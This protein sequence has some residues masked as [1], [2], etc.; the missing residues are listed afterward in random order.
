MLP[1]HAAARAPKVLCLTT[2]CPKQRTHT[3]PPR[4]C[5]AARARLH[6]GAQISDGPCNTAGIPIKRLRGIKRLEF[7]T[8]TNGD[9]RNRKVYSPNIAGPS[10][11]SVILTDCIEH[12]GEQDP[13]GKCAG[14]RMT[15]ACYDLSFP[16]P[17]QTRSRRSSRG[18][19][20]EPCV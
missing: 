6:A 1:P 10:A 8:D 14:G 2:C 20:T 11:Q 13:T 4:A 17:P 15:I 18:E 5:S 9:A 7:T 3:M 12:S 16:A 19:R